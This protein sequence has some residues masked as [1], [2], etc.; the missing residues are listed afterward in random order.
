[1]FRNR[2]NLFQMQWYVFGE[3]IVGMILDFTVYLKMSATHL[4]FAAPYSLI[5]NL[6]SVLASL[7]VFRGTQ[8]VAPNQSILQT[9]SLPLFRRHCDVLPL[10]VFTTGLMKIYSAC[11]HINIIYFFNLRVLG[12]RSHDHVIRNIALGFILAA[13]KCLCFRS[14]HLVSLVRKRVY[15]GLSNLYILFRD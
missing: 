7:I 11:W 5:L 9:R 6:V 8:I 12:Y 13:T 1:M 15:G 3:I 2:F 10:M 14:V 4:N